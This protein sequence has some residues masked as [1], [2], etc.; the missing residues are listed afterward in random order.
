VKPLPLAI[1][2]LALTIGISQA[3]LFDDDEALVKRY[4]NQTNSPLDNF[5][6]K[7]PGKRLVFLHSHQYFSPA[8]R[9]RQSGWLYQLEGEGRKSTHKRWTYLQAPPSLPRLRCCLARSRLVSPWRAA[10][11]AGCPEPPR[12]RCCLARSRSSRPSGCTTC[13]LPRAFPGSG[14]ASLAPA[15]LALPGC[16]AVQ[17]APSL[18]RL[19]CSDPR[20][21]ALLSTAG[22]RPQSVSVIIPT[23][24]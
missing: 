16:T 1:S 24:R 19:R 9:P 12:L 17:A 6:P 20:L 8:A 3:D 5:R 23:M 21:F 18:P 14:V 4:G 2:L 22:D 11:P 15:R 13:R 7:L 10:L